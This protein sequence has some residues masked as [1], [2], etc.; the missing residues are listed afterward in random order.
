MAHRVALETLSFP[1]HTRIHR[2]I[3]LFPTCITASLTQTLY[4]LRSIVKFLDSR[5]QKPLVVPWR[6]LS[7]TRYAKLLVVVMMVHT[8]C[9]TMRHWTLSRGNDLY[10]MENPCQGM[11]VEGV[12]DPL[13]DF[14]LLDRFV[15]GEEIRLGRVVSKL[16]ERLERKVIFN[17]TGDWK[18]RINWVIM[19]DDK[20]GCSEMTR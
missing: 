7:S 1:I 6:V 13:L 17:S 5:L 9:Y 2:I 20:V 8:Y 10:T 18:L 4:S 11:V 14:Q 3:R 12:L 19:L 16:V 15:D